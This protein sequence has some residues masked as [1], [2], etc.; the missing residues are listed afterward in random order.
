MFK[1]KLRTVLLC[2]AL[3]F[4]VLSGAPVRPEEIRALMQ[5]LNQPRLAHTLPEKEDD[6]GPPPEDGR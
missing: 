4:G 2:A 3:E 5:Q 6:G 1:G